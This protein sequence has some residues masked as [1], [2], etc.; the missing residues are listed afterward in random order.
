MG[1]FDVFLDLKQGETV[2]AE[3]ALDDNL[4]HLGEQV[5]R[6]LEDVVRLDLLLVHRAFAI[7]S[8]NEEEGLTP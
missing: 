5:G 4:A 3:L 6:R 7:A 1:F 2:H 8:R